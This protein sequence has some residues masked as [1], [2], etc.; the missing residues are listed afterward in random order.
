M[1]GTV[2]PGELLGSAVGCVEVLRLR[3]RVGVGPS[4]VGRPYLLDAR[5]TPEGLRLGSATTGDRMLRRA[6]WVGAGGEH[7]T[8]IDPDAGGRGVVQIRRHTPS[9]VGDHLAVPTDRGVLFVPLAVDA[10]R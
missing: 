2:Q 1:A 10:A 7:V 6:E 5:A 9:R 8:W 3:G 4:R